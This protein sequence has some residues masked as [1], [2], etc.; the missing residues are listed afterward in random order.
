MPSPAGPTR[1]ERR[2]TVIATLALATILAWAW[3]V[4]VARAPGVSAGMSMDMPSMAATDSSGAGLLS[5]FAMWVE[6]G[7]AHV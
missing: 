4:H 6:I 1:P 7:R 5:L 3:V 2:L